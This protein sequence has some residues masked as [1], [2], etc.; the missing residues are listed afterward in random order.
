MILS[1]LFSLPGPAINLYLLQTPMFQ[2]V[3]LIVHQAHELLLGNLKVRNPQRLVG[4][5]LGCLHEALSKIHAPSMLCESSCCCC[6]CSCC[7]VTRSCPT[8]CEPI[9]CS[10]P[11]FMGSSRQEYWSELPFPSSGDFPGPVF[12]ISSRFFT[13]EPPGK[14]CAAVTPALSQPHCAAHLSVLD[15]AEEK[16]ASLEASCTA[17]E[18]RSSITCSHLAR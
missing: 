16:W 10:M 4:S 9:E 14:P 17:E 11:G 12:C 13:T 3:C 8:L 6:Y 15:G 18:A 7:S 5:L 1:H 2:L